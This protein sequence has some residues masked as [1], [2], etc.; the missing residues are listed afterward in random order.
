MFIPTRI[1]GLVPRVRDPLESRTDSHEWLSA[2]FHQKNLLFPLVS[3]PSWNASLL[4]KQ[5]YLIC[6]PLLSYGISYQ[7]LHYVKMQNIWLRGRQ[8][9]S[10]TLLTHSH[11]RHTHTHTH[12]HTTQHTHTHTHTDHRHTHTPTTHTD[13]PTHITTHTHTHHTHTHTTPHTHTDRH[14]H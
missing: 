7:E 1:Y 3:S 9:H 4:Y 6:I 10:L 12:T 11:H 2:W 14:T 8:T 13:T 5:S